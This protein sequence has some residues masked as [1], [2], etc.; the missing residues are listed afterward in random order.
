LMKRFAPV[1]LIAVLGLASLS[2]MAVNRALFGEPP[3]PTPIPPTLI[4]VPTLTPTLVPTITLTPDSCPN[5]DCIT[6][7][8]DQIHSMS[9]SGGVGGE[10]RTTR[11][12]LDAKGIYVLV[13]YTIDGDQIRDPIDERGLSESL[14]DYQ[15]D[16]QTQQRIWDYF[17]AIIPPEQRTF[18]DAFIIFTDGKEN[19]LASV[20]QSR[21]SADE[22]VLGVDIVDATNPKD[23]TFTLVHEYGHLLTLNPSQVVPS[24][25]IFDH[26]HSDKI[27]QQEAN[28]CQTYFSG[29]GCSNSNSYIN[30]FFARFW[31]KI[32]AEW[33][34]IDRIENEDDLYRALEKFYKKYKDQF[35]TD[36]APTSPAEDI[37]ESFSFFILRPKPTGD[38]IADQ[39]V[40][41]F[42]EFPELVQLRTQMGHRLC[43]QV[44]K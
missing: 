24:Q 27:Y 23:L 12:S 40:L 5:G 16:R 38:T 13:A 29:E 10:S 17:A 21:N 44:E 43:A 42:Y 22:W 8:V 41:F 28:T 7:C 33:S 36:Y 19:L 9:Q 34:D 26:P 3:T 18:L 11:R 4:P 1:F 37:A 32:Y 25:L 31:S 35:V 14:T 15:K 20:S 6:A 30:K 39:K 2:C